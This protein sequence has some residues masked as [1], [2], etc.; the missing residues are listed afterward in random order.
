MGRIKKAIFH[1]Q[2]NIP[3]LFRVWRCPTGNYLLFDSRA[4]GVAGRRL[5][6][7]RRA[8]DPSAHATGNQLRLGSHARRR[9]VAHDPARAGR[10]GL[11]RSRDALGFG[12]LHRH[13]LHRAVLRVPSPR[14]ARRR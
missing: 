1:Q 2:F 9:A 4:A 8:L 7:T 5:D 10:T 11:D 14:R 3:L 13:V 12:R 6:S